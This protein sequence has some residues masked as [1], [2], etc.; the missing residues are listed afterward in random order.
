VHLEGGQHVVEKAD[1][2]FDL[3]F[4]LPVKGKGYGD[5]GLPRFS[6]DLRRLS[7]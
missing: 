1:A 3:P 6:C 5:V 2:G 7:S 4:A